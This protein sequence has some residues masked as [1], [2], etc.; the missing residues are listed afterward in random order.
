MKNSTLKRRP[1]PGVAT[2]EVSLASLASARSDVCPQG[3]RL[4]VRQVVS[5]KGPV[6]SAWSSQVSRVQGLKKWAGDRRGLES[7]G[8][9]LSTPRGLASYGQREHVAERR[10]ALWAGRLSRV[11]ARGAVAPAGRPAVAVAAAAS[12]GAGVAPRRRPISE[13]LTAAR[14]RRRPSSVVSSVRAVWSSPVLGRRAAGV[15]AAAAR[16]GAA[17]GAVA[18]PQG[19][20]RGG[21]RGAGYAAGAA[22]AAVRR[23]R[24]GRG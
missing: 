17:Y 16:S 10:P 14:R 6:L 2:A 4:R 5:T 12:S 19:A 20:P 1:S 18:A 11:P 13:V 3:G 21:A 7:E 15:A 9:V 8:L 22:S 24:G 23:P